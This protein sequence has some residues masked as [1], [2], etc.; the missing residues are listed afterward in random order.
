ML[1]KQQISDRVTELNTAVHEAWRRAAGAE[2]ERQKAERDDLQAQCLAS[3]GHVFGFNDALVRVR[4]CKVC[5]AQPVADLG[6]RSPVVGTNELPPLSPLFDGQVS[7]QGQRTVEFDP[8][9]VRELA[10]ALPRATLH[11]FATSST[12]EPASGSSD[13]EAPR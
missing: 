12:A 7:V 4:M 2:R 13:P 10:A 3:G 6:I 8:A 1:T 9:G 5:H 11:P